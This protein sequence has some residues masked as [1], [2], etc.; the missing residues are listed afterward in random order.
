MSSTKF[1]YIINEKTVLDHPGLLSGRINQI[2]YSLGQQ[3][4]DHQFRR[5]SVDQVQIEEALHRRVVQLREK[6]D[7]IR[8]WFGGGRDC[9]LALDTFIRYNIKIDEIVVARRCTE[10]GQGLFPDFDP[11]T[12]ID[13]AAIQWL[14]QNKSRFPDTKITVLNFDDQHH[15][16]VF[17]NPR[18]YWYT[19]EWFFS[20]SYLPQ[21]FHRFVN[22]RFNMLENHVGQCELVGSTTPTVIQ[23]DVDLSWK[24]YFSDASF[25][26]VGA[27]Q[28]PDINFEDFLITDDDPE[29]MNLHV[30]S[31]VDDYERTGERADY[32]K[33][34]RQQ[35]RTVRNRSLFYQN[36][37]Y[38]ELQL[39]KN[40]VDLEFPS[41]DYFWRAGQSTRTYYEMINRY[42]DGNPVECLRLYRDNTDWDLIKRLR[43]NGSPCTRVWKLTQK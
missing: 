17:E 40:D 27:S 28:D 4:D 43:T 19:T 38:N 14:D 2:R 9:R 26:S 30:N 21:V 3:F 22:P 23:D 13:S 29:L 24:F 12:E 39:T 16:S 6:Y 20:V 34:W 35:E 11:L 18:W 25:S 15:Q 1:K 42:R 32:S 41:G 10:N 31:I 36:Q 33:N 5:R 8:L 7:Y 37:N